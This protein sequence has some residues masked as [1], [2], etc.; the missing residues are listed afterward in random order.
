MMNR[1]QMLK[2][3]GAFL[4]AGIPW[5]HQL[6]ARAGEAG[7]T[8]RRKSC[9]LL[10]MPGGP[11]QAHT[12]DPRPGENEG[13]APVPTSVP[14]IQIC[15][16]LP[17]MSQQMH[18]LALL[19]TMETRD[20]THDSAQPMMLT[21]YRPNAGGIR[22]PTLG[23]VVACEFAQA[24]AE[25]PN[26]V[27]LSQAGMEH[28]TP[29]YLG[30]RHAPFVTAPGQG[31]PDVNPAAGLTLDDLQQRTALLD[32][33]SR[34]FV[35][36]YPGQAPAAHATTLQRAERLM[37]SSRLAA[38]DLTREPQ[39]LHSAYGPTSFGQQCLQARRLIEA[40]VPFVQ[41]ACSPPEAS[42]PGRTQWDCHTETQPT[43]R[44]VLL[45]SL[46]RPMAALLEDLSMRG[47]LET[48]L[49]IWMGEFGRSRNGQNHNPR[50]WCVALAGAGVRGG[51]AMGGATT[52]NG[53][54]PVNTADLYATFM[55]ALDIDQG[56]EHV[57][58]NGR[59][60]NIVDGGNRARPVN[61]IF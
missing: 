1:R 2:T 23:S 53:Y 14:G 44:N 33:L 41:V 48:T 18:H 32:R 6:A 59:P 55:K 7:Q 30:A 11:S 35:Q 24:D 39:Q 42:G 57:L 5:F 38:F 26:F 60:I 46:D 27:C 21:G 49:V 43:L 47:L 51:V 31:V 50:N 37:R 36:R 54:R 20:G 19:R 58:R 10:W 45:P 34:D 22:H 4:V 29:A 8:R 3:T 9:I 13:F 12:F 61:E 17:K 52:P 40:G 15:E 28:L 25:L 56:K 16:H